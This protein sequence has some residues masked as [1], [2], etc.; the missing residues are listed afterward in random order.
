MTTGV[1]HKGEFVDFWLNDASDRTWIERTIAAKGWLRQDVEVYLYELARSGSE[2]LSF[3]ASKNL[4]KIRLEMQ[5]VSDG[6][7]GT[8]QVQT[9]V[10]EQTYQKIPHYLN[11]SLV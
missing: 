10:V 5:Q 2:I 7:G 1:F 3:D 6:Q 4:Q 8:V 11:G 9:V